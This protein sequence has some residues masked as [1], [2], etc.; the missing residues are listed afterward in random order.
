MRRPIPRPDF[1]GNQV[2]AGFGIRYAQQRLGQAHE[3]EPFGIRQTEFLK[4]ALHHA[5]L[6]SAAAGDFHQFASA[7][8]SRQPGAI[9]KRRL[10]QQP[11]KQR[12]LIVKFVSVQD[13]PVRGVEW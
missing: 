2:V 8:Y 5:F 6:A 13:V 10:L 3:R 4:K 9:I 7:T 11:L 12:L 1:L